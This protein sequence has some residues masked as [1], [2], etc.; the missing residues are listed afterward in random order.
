M[1]QSGVWIVVRVGG[2]RRGDEALDGEGVDPHRREDAADLGENVFDGRLDEVLGGCK[3]H[4]QVLCEMCIGLRAESCHWG[5]PGRIRARN[6]AIGEAGAILKW[7]NGFEHVWCE[8][9]EEPLARKFGA[10]G[11]VAR[12]FVSYNGVEELEVFPVTV[13]NDLQSPDQSAF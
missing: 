8:D 2:G 11:G 10:F 13:H 4:G 3:V 12:C 5:Y 1:L 9:N 6:G 7:D